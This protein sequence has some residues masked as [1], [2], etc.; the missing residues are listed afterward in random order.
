M[1]GGAVI[2]F[3][4]PATGLSVLA[5]A[6][7]LW[8]HDRHAYFWF[9]TRFFPNPWD[10]PFLDLD[11]IPAAIACWAK[12]VDVYVANTCDSLSRAHDYSPLWLRAT[13]LPLERDWTPVYG[14]GLASLFCASL[15]LLP[16]PGSWRDLRFIVPAALSSSTVYAVERGNVDLFLFLLAMAAAVL[17][18]RAYALRLA[19]YALIVLAGLLKF[20]P[21]A[22][23]AI[24]TRERPKAFAVA[25]TL[26]TV[27]IAACAMLFHDEL[28][29]MAPNIPAAGSPFTDLFGAA[30]LPGGFGRFARAGAHAMGFGGPALQALQEHAVLKSALAAGL[31]GGAA[32]IVVRLAFHARLNDAFATLSPLETGQC[33]IAAW[34]IC[35]CFVAGQSVAYRAVFLLPLL[36]VLLNLARFPG[37]GGARTALRAAAWCIVG[38]MWWPG[39]RSLA[40]EGKF[41][42]F[43]PPPEDLPNLLLWLVHELAWWWLFAVLMGLL[44]VFVR[45]SVLPR[46]LT[47]IPRAWLASPRF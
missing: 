41:A 7:F 44:A 10:F 18:T 28:R 39:L 17:W 47:F 33:A 43:A 6:T 11:Y 23:L 30:Q 3:V 20:Y 25:L 5:L 38:L 24:Q 13:F 9:V 34:T 32:L 21:L 16:R 29:R 35:G 46:H 12:G 26:S 45:Q 27:A 31:F 40:G 2:R 37:A 14:L 36:P 8:S 4:V 19:A 22:A 1:A 42:E 15:A